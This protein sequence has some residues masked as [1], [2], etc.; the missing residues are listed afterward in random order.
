MPAP[1]AQ[2]LIVYNPDITSPNSGAWAFG[3]IMNVTWDN[4]NMP[5]QAQ[6][7]KGTVILGHYLDDGD[8]SL[9]VEHPLAREFALA[10]RQTYVTMPTDVEARDDYFIVLLGDSGNKSPNFRLFDPDTCDE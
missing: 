10:D 6:D 9:D 5:A 8:M 7:N 4:S 2:T 1:K 3:S